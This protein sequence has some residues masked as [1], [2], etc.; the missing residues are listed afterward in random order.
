MTR[1]TVLAGSTSFRCVSV[2]FTPCRVVVYVNVASCF[3][4][5]RL[6]FHASLIQLEINRVCLSFACHAAA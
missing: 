6:Y 5:L 4:N 3:Y 2:V 1:H